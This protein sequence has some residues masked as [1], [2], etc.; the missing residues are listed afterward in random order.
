MGAIRR[1][2]LHQSRNFEVE[3]LYTHRIA[4]YDYRKG[5]DEWL[6]NCSPQPPQKI[7]IAFD[8]WNLLS[9][10]FAVLL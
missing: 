9:Y 7:I 1:R 2:R 10:Y 4:V 5:F 6:G 8:V 3:R